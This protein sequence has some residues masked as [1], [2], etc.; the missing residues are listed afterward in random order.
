MAPRSHDIILVSIT[1]CPPP[2][3]SEQLLFD[4][5][6]SKQHAA[7]C[8]LRTPDSHALR[9]VW[10]HY[11]HLQV[12]SS[13]R[14]PQAVARRHDIQIP[15]ATTERHMA[16][17]TR[18]AVTFATFPSEMLQMVGCYLSLWD[19]SA[20]SELRKAVPPGVCPWFR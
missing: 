18:P 16:N 6:N 5:T 14:D 1:P 19:L 17:Q 13:L 9:S 4:R 7:H 11:A 20:L 15:W 8:R 12:V 3:S 10:L 2:T